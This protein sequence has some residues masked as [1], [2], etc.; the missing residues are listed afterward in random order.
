[1]TKE[2]STLAVAG[3][4]VGLR[5]ALLSPFLPKLLARVRSK[6]ISREFQALSSLAD[7]ELL[8]CP[9]HVAD[10]RLAPRELLV[11]FN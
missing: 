7:H 3:S 6:P 11:S 9:D 10:N 2:M 1:M 8:S 4:F 5:H